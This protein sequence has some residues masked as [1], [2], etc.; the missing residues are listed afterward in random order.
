MFLNQAFAVCFYFEDDIIVNHEIGY[1]VM[2]QNSVFV[3]D[4]ILLLAVE[5]NAVKAKLVFERIFVHYFQEDRT[6]DIMDLHA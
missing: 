1:K 2:G 3:D 4:F 6:K 5:W